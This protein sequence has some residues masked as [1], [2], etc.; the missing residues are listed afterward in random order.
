[1][2][3]TI[4]QTGGQLEEWRIEQGLTQIE[5]SQALHTTP[6]ALQRWKEEPDKL[7]KYETKCAFVIAL[8]GLE[9]I[10]KSEIP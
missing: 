7:L 3:I 6:R 9:E 10:V 4:P 2:R 1:M 8:L 5:L